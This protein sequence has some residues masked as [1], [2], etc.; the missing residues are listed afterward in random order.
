MCPAVQYCTAV[1]LLVPHVYL[2]P[3]VHCGEQALFEFSGNA[4]VHGTV[5]IGL[6]ACMNEVRTAVSRLTTLCF[7]SK[8][9]PGINSLLLVAAD[10]SLRAPLPA[11]AAIDD[12]EFEARVTLSEYQ[13]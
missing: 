3:V 6:M 4:E 2:V 11:F 12:G 8:L 10:C 1:P 7:V 5:R 9:I 13:A